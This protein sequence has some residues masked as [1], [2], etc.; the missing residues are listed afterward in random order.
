MGAHIVGDK[1]L[2]HSHGLIGAGTHIPAVILRKGHSKLGL[3]IDVNV[4]PEGLLEGGIEVIGGIEYPIAVCVGGGGHIDDIGVSLQGYLGLDYVLGLKLEGVDLR[5]LVGGAG[6]DEIGNVLRLRYEPLHGDRFKGGVNFHGVIFYAVRGGFK[7]EHSFL[8]GRYHRGTI[9]LIICA[10]YGRGVII[11]VIAVGHI[12]IAEGHG[13]AVYREG[14]GDAG[15]VSAVGVNGHGSNYVINGTG[16]VQHQVHLHLGVRRVEGGVVAG[17]VGYARIGESVFHIEIS[18]SAYRGH[19]GIRYCGGHRGFHHCAGDVADIGGRARH[20]VNINAHRLVPRF[21]I[22]L[23]IYLGNGDGYLISMIL[24]EG[25]EQGQRCG[26]ASYEVIEADASLG[27]ARCGDAGVAQ[28]YPAFIARDGANILARGKHGQGRIVGIGNGAAAAVQSAYIHIEVHELVAHEQDVVIDA[29]SHVV[30]GLRAHLEAH[31]Y[32]GFPACIYRAITA[33]M[34]RRAA[35]FTAQIHLGEGYGKGIQIGGIPHGVFVVGDI[36]DVAYLKAVGTAGGQVYCRAAFEQ[37]YSL[38]LLHIDLDMPVIYPRAI[39]HLGVAGP[40]PY[41]ILGGAVLVQK[42]H[43]S[44][45]QVHKGGEGTLVAGK[46]LIVKVNVYQTLGVLHALAEYQPYVGIGQWLGT[47]VV[48]G[49]VKGLGDRGNIRIKGVGGYELDRFGI[50]SGRVLGHIVNIIGGGGRKTGN[51]DGEVGIGLCRGLSCLQHVAHAVFH[52]Y[53]GRA[54][55]KAGGGGAGNGGI[56][57]SVEHCYPIEGGRLVDGCGQGNGVLG[58][59]GDRGLVGEH[60]SRSVDGDEGQL[61]NIGAQA[62]VGVNEHHVKLIF[63]ELLEVAAVHGKHVYD[64]L[65]DLAHSVA[66]AAAYG[67]GSKF[68]YAGLGAA[69]GQEHVIEIAGLGGHHRDLGGVVGDF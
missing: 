67:A 16:S 27:A 44:P 64:V 33:D 50:V 55:V 56:L 4:T 65:A 15:L 45:Q 3:S 19:G 14:C 42:L 46:I 62:A 66:E 57:L 10:V 2:H 47:G 12:V 11:P 60:G 43:V 20:N 9:L 51:I 37:E 52:V 34:I 22:R 29:V 26:A 5:E 49:L 68:A 24:A 23:R 6:N 39:Y 63:G 1:R 61:F 7:G 54:A 36:A 40:L 58:N 18:G 31:I 48:S 35:G 13:S 28:I 32:T 38:A 25:V 21:I 17:K 59:A 69:L 30:G 41:G 53:L 8:G